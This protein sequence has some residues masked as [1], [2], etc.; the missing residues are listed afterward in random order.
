[1]AL[2]VPT[3]LLRVADTEAM[4]PVRVW[5]VPTVPLRV[6]G[7]VTVNWPPKASDAVLANHAAA[8]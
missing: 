3:E 7:T 1:M 2:E 5:P 4:L 8:T 6:K